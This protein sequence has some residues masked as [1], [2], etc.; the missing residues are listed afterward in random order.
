MNM[1]PSKNRY[2]HWM[3]HKQ[4]CFARLKRR[5]TILEVRVIIAMLAMQNIS[6][7]EIFNNK[8]IE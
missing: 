4:T 5:S 1:T 7:K 6:F 3:F 8:N 2:F